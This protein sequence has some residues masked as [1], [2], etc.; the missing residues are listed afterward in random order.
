MRKSIAEQGGS[1]EGQLAR[2]VESYGNN[3]S[4]FRPGATNS[5]GSAP[6]ESGTQPGWQRPVQPSQALHDSF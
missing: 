5:L 1:L 6:A 3:W 4:G 2:G